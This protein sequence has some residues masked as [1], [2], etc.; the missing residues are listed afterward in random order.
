MINFSSMAKISLWLITVKNIL[1]C[2][3]KGMYAYVCEYFVDMRQNTHNI[4][5]K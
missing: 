2:S 4:H 5:T 3:F 1:K